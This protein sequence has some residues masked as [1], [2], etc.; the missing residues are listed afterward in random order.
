[1]ALGVDVESFGSTTFKRDD[2]ERGFEPDSCFYITNAA[3]MLGKSTIDLAKDP[4]PEL[5]IEIDITSASI[6]KLPIYAQVGVSEVWRYDGAKLFMFKL[7]DGEYVNIEQSLYFPALGAQ[8]L[9]KFLDD[10]KITSRRELIQ[11]FRD[12]LRR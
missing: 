2:L 8:D 1:M 7:A 11:S 6:R 5:V 12:W 10:S 4:P 9:V 3:R